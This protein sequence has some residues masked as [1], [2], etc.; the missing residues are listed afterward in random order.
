VEAEDLQLELPVIA[1]PV[2]LLR[3]LNLVKLNLVNLA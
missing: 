2:Q 1:F 3:K